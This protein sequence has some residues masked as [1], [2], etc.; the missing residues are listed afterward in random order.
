MAISV[1]NIAVLP[2]RLPFTTKVKYGDHTIEQRS[3][4]FLVRFSDGTKKEFDN[5]EDVMNAFRKMENNMN[6]EAEKTS[7]YNV[8]PDEWATD[9][10]PVF[11]VDDDDYM[12]GAKR[13]PDKKWNFNDDRINKAIRNS[14]YKRLSFWLTHK[15]EPNRSYKF[16]RPKS[17]KHKKNEDI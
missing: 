12:R 15:D 7:F 4:K 1:S 11:H 6:E 5:I 16:V 17:Q 9:G 14:G 8:E 13:K 10:S 3:E 2:K